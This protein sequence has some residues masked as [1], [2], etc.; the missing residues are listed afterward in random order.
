MWHDPMTGVF[1][2]AYINHRV[3]FNTQDVFLKR[4]V[5]DDGLT[6]AFAYMSI[7]CN[8]GIPKAVPT[9]VLCALP[10]DPDIANLG[11]R[12]AA[13]RQQL[14]YKYKLVKR[15]PPK[16]AKEYQVLGRQL[17]SARKSFKDAITREFK[18]DYRFRFH[19]KQ[20]KRQL[21]KTIVANVYVEPV[22][23]H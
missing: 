11:R 6:H 12:H 18:R 1:S 15:A 16:E 17:T 20:I 23:Q 4:D 13:M 22:V 14:R 7:R 10:P 5:S 3:K 9:A 8:P 19:N 21:D 2:G